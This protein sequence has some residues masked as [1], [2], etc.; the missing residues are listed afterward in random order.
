MRSY[1]SHRNIA[2]R[3]AI[4]N[5]GNHNFRKQTH[6]NKGEEEL[7]KAEPIDTE[8]LLKEAKTAEHKEAYMIVERN[9]TFRVGVGARANSLEEP[10]FFIEVNIR[11]SEETGEVNLL[12][13]SRALK[14]LKSL[15]AK[16]YSLT[17]QD[18]TCISCEKAKDIQNLTEEYNEVISLLK[19][20]LDNPK[21]EF[22]QT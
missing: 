15:Q 14:C 10:P 3:K 17:Y 20:S 21:E 6:R 11:L 18:G 12:K 19:N 22:E 4:Q 8:K 5:L 2:I 1:S 9:E 16:G 7:K 13:L